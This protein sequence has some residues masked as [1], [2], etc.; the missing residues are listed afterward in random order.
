MITADLTYKIYGLGGHSQGPF[1]T[2]NPILAGLDFIRL[3]NER[4]LYGFDSFDAVSVKPVALD[5]GTK[6]NI[7]PENAVLKVE[8]AAE[9]ERQYEHLLDIFANTS[10]AVEKNWDV[11]FEVNILVK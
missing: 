10:S 6:G 9:E 5:A 8:I 1:K 2:K 4:V 11:T 3:I 7:I